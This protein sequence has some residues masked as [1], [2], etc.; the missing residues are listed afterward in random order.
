MKNFLSLFSLKNIRETAQN[1][2]ERFPLPAVLLLVNT[3]F[4][5]YQ[6]QISETSDLIMQTI[7]TLVVTFFLATG[8]ALFS[9]SLKTKY[10]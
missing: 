8:V 5:L 1:L 7:L 9:E 2:W 4:I 10:P 6:I 3:G